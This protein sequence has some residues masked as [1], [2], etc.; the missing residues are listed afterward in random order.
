MEIR[1]WNFIRK[2]SQGDKSMNL[3]LFKKVAL[4]TSGLATCLFMVGT[5][6]RVSAQTTQNCL[7][8]TAPQVTHG[9]AR[10]TGLPDGDQFLLPTTHQWTVVTQSPGASVFTANTQNFGNNPGF[11]AGTSPQGLVS[12]AP[13]SVIRAI[14]CQ[15]DLWDLNF[16]LATNGNSV[17]DMVTIFLQNTAGSQVTPLA[18]FTVEANG[19]RVTQRNVQTHLNDRFAIGATVTGLFLDSLIPLTDNAGTN[20]KRTGLITFA[21]LPMGVCL[22]IGIEI[23]RG[24]GTGST[25]IVVNDVVVNRKEQAGD[26]NLSGVGLL[27]GLTG[28]YPTMK[29]CAEACVPCPPVSGGGGGPAKCVTACFSAPEYY[30]LKYECLI[31]T[32]FDFGTVIIGGQNFNNPILVDKCPERVL[33]VL[34]GSPFFGPA[35]TPLGRL[36]RQYVAAQLSLNRHGGYGSPAVIDIL[37]SNLSC[38]MLMFQPVTL[39]NGAT[40]SQDSMLKDLFEQTLF[41][42]KANRTADMTK[43]TAIWQMLNGDSPNLV[44]NRPLRD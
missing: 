32:D 4:L 16:Y 13:G 8:F 38:Y 26:R 22:H 37:W 9:F 41:A 23:K 40:I 11:F 25:A 17:G 39:G 29:P 44:C 27:G 2:Y 19:I 34:K 24:N 15:D 28:G 43:L 18:M 36:N 1:L 31:D 33:W 10:G 42:I 5:L 20:G 21:G 30:A 6:G 12:T 35:A 14:S 3:K 7:Q